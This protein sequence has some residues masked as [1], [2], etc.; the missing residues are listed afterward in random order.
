V[1]RRR[2]G[3]WPIHMPI[4]AVAPRSVV[5]RLRRI[6]YVHRSLKITDEQREGFAVLY[7]ET[8]DEAGLPGDEPFRE[9][10]PHLEFGSRVAQQNARG[11]D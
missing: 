3:S 9:Q 6:I 11:R 10:C 5:R 1:P 4:G 2:R 7:L 8:L